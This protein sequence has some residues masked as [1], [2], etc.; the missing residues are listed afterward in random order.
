MYEMVKNIVSF[1]HSGYDLD[2]NV[3]FRILLFECARQTTG[4]NLVSCVLSVIWLIS[5]L[6]IRL[7][8]DVLPHC[9]VYQI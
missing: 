3:D 5:T 8:W 4:F 6:R 1:I 9:E 2:E 7:N